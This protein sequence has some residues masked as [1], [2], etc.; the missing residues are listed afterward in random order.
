MKH[1]THKHHI[2]PKHAGG[3][4]EESNIVEL[5]VEDHAKAHR[6]LYETYGRWQDK[7]AWLALSGRIGKEEIIRMKQSESAKATVYTPEKRLNMSRGQKGKKHSKETCAKRSVAY[8]GDGNSFFGKKHSDETKALMS[9]RAQGR[10]LSKE[11]KDKISERTKGIPKPKIA[12]P[13]C[14]VVGG[15]PVMKRHHFDNCKIF[16]EEFEKSLQQIMK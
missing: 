4:D 6:E 14:S 5:S 12:C 11:T 1:L 9:E 7:I 2:L 16:A 15:I 3:T 13:H 8:T 10:I